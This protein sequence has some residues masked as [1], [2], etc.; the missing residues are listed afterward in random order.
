MLRPDCEIAR[1]HLSTILKK[2]NSYT[3]SYLV[4][5]GLKW[6]SSLFALAFNFSIF[7]L[8][9]VKVGDGETHHYHHYHNDYD[10][11]CCQ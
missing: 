2:H 7:Q 11:Y 1:G 9:K 5:I 3:F 4:S 6:G 8:I 10:Q